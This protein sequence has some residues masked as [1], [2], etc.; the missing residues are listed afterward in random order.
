MRLRLLDGR[1]CVCQV[2]DFSGIS[3]Y[4][5]VFFLARTDKECSLVCREDFVPANAIQQESGWRALEVVGP[6]DFS[7]VGILAGLSGILAEQGISV[8]AISTFDTD[9]LMVR[10]GQIDE[11][12]SALEQG[13]HTI[14][15]LPG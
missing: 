15:F 4:G 12:I 11:A 9:Y 2:P 1:F 5:R 7:L 10:E 3:Q 14:D 6:L 13:G 8:F